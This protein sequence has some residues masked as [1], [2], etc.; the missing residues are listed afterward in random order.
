MNS[1]RYESAV[2][3]GRYISVSGLGVK[4]YILAKIACILCC[5]LF[6]RVPS[7]IIRHKHEFSWWEIW[8][9]PRPPPTPTHHSDQSYIVYW[10]GL[11]PYEY[12]HWPQ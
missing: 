3:Q 5:L 4:S 7:N 12:D 11:Y 9:R 1:W 2:I 6:C 10:L 8:A